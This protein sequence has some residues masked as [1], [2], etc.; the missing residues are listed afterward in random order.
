MRNEL[1]LCT[2]IWIAAG[3]IK[4]A[5]LSSTAARKD[6]RSVQQ[7][8]N[9][10]KRIID[11]QMQR[12][13]QEL[14]SAEAL[15]RGLPRTENRRDDANRIQFKTPDQR[16]LRDKEF[17]LQTPE[18][19]GCSPKTPMASVQQRRA[20]HAKSA[21]TVG[22]KD[23]ERIAPEQRRMAASPDR[24]DGADLQGRH[25]RT[26]RTRIPAARTTRR[27][28]SKIPTPRP[29]YKG[30]YHRPGS[31]M[32]PRGPCQGDETNKTQERM[33]P[34]TPDRTEMAEPAPDL[35]SILELTDEH[36]EL[37]AAFPDAKHPIFG[38]PFAQRCPVHRKGNLDD[39]YVPT[40]GLEYFD[41]FVAAMP[42]VYSFPSPSH[43]HQSTKLKTVHSA[44]KNV[45]Y[46]ARRIGRTDPFDQEK[47]FDD[48]NFLDPAL[49]A[50]ARKGGY[51]DTSSS[52]SEYA[53]LIS[54]SLRRRCHGKG[55]AGKLSI[56]ILLPTCFFVKQT[57]SLACKSAKVFL[58]M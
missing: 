50:V 16:A 32:Q 35:A 7:K 20:K 44:G 8:I 13:D 45:G 48:S 5:T 34:P 14:E 49:D 29:D 2:K 55:S 36:G 57:F 33:A 46:S 6:E 39:H 11:A 23:S 51:L 10:I 4:D 41:E 1:L 38:W 9:D 12:P 40:G 31:G 30:R 42:S 53:A 17:I 22:P 37:A 58:L 56:F 21:S 15:N 52:E 43:R 19:S 54:S 28:G 47:L 27:R 24:V 25:G 26:N 18:A 3:E